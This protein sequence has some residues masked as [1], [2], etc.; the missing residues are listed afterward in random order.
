MHLQNWK[1]NCEAPFCTKGTDTSKV[2]LIYSRSTVHVGMFLVLSFAVCSSSRGTFLLKSAVTS[3]TPVKVLVSMVYSP[4]CDNC[5]KDQFHISQM[6]SLNKGQTCIIKEGGSICCDWQAN[7]CLTVWALSVSVSSAAEEDIENSCLWNKMYF[8]HSV[9]V[10]K[11]LHE[12]CSLR[13]VSWSLLVLN[14]R[15]WCNLAAL[16]N[17]SINMYWII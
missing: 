6:F 3:M 14:Y 16:A 9:V 1:V 10:F 7:L 4:L 17:V 2:F 15:V 13:I 8:S 5:M 12:H 11:V